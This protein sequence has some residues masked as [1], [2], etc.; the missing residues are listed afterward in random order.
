M[1]L[2]DKITIIYV[3]STTRKIVKMTNKDIYLHA[4]TFVKGRNSKD[5]IFGE[6]QFD[7]PI[8]AP[9]R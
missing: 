1:E 6:W 5:P 9:I 7:R 3:H 4:S 8:T 2:L